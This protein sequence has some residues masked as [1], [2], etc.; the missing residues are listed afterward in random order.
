MINLIKILLRFGSFDI[1]FTKTQSRIS[2]YLCSK[3]SYIS[4]NFTL[5]LWHK[6]FVNFR[7]F[8]QRKFVNT[9]ITA[10]LRKIKGFFGEKGEIPFPYNSIL[11]IFYNKN[12]SGWQFMGQFK[13]PG[14]FQIFQVFPGQSCSIFQIRLK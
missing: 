5:R 8:E 10:V 3:T 1:N 12:K 9:R 7:T 14:N 6:N 11:L 4:S 2:R 13:I